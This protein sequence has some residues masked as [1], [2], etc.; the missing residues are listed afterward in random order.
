MAPSSLNCVSSQSLVSSN[1][2]LTP[3]SPTSHNN[4]G[5]ACS[6]RDNSNGQTHAH[7]CNDR[8]RGLLVNSSGQQKGSCSN[9]V[10]VSNSMNEH[11]EE[12]KLEENKTAS[13][14]LKSLTEGNKEHISL[15]MKQSVPVHLLLTYEE[16]CEL[17]KRC[18]KPLTTSDNIGAQEFDILVTD[19]IDSCHFWA[20]V[21][22]QVRLNEGK[23]G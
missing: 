20:N 8:D 3:Q 5:S 10:D 14:S 22:D 15:S 17:L 9:A 12:R 23:R 2:S 13:S 19:V 18:N 11:K 16:M 1:D 4:S 6:S 21:D 7:Q